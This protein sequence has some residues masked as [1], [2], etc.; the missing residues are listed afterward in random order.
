MSPAPATLSERPT[1]SLSPSRASDFATCPLLFRFRT[2]DRLPEP[3]SAAA[4]RG[5]LVHS[6]LER[7]F[8]LPPRERN[9]AR[10]S[11]L[12][13][14]CWADMVAQE[15]ELAELAAQEAGS[16]PHAGEQQAQGCDPWLAGATELLAC[17]FELEDPTRLEPVGRELALQ[18][19]LPSGLTLRGFI[20]RLDQAAD[21]AL[22]VVDYKTGRAPG[23]GYEARA[24]FQ[25]RFYALALWR[26]RGVIPRLLQLMYLSTGVVLR[27][28]PDELDLRSTERK[29]EALWAAIERAI[30]TGDWRANP[31]RLCDWCAHKAL[32]PAWGGQ[33]P[34][35]PV[36]EIPGVPQ[37]GADQAHN[38]PRTER[39]SAA[40]SSEAE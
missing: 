20:D 18:V 40:G 8:D 2:I 13:P 39:A 15:P 32:C 28:E 38:Q 19:E 10:A 24:M 6:V 36:P 9:L 22:R 27:Y 7:L 4:A 11:E 25:M 35:L 31:S 21:G 26:E 34:P 5:T 16:G 1:R 33:P 23:P 3:P 37:V 29:V 12:L 14:G 30:T 17:Y